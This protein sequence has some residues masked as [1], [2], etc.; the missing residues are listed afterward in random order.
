MDLLNSPDNKEILLAI[1]LG[2]GDKSSPVNNF[3]SSRE[4]LSEILRWYE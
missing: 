4:N 3:K 2:Y 1:A